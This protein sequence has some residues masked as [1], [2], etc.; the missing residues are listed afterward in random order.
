M[1]VISAQDSSVRNLLPFAVKS[2]TTRT[3]ERSETAS[4]RLPEGGAKPATPL[5]RKAVTS[6][7]SPQSLRLP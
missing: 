5:R 7:R 3:A 2:P 6:H 4:Q 1:G